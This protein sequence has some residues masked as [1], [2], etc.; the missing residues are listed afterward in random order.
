MSLGPSTRLGPYE[1]VGPIG[2]GGMGEVYRARDGR[3][4]RDV[5]IKILPTSL[6]RDSDRLAR[7]EREAQILAALNHPN[8]AAIHHVEETSDGPALVMELVEGETLAER[9]SRGPIPL[10]EAL[11]IAKQIAE[12]LE[13]AH[14]QGIIH[15]DLKPA[16]IKLRDD[17]TVKVLDFGL[18]KL[19]EPFGVNAPNALS[20]SPTITSPA[21]TGVGVLLGTAAYMSPEQ[22]KGLAA[23][24]RSDVFAFG[25]VLFEVLTGRQAFQ[26]ETVAE[27]LGAVLV[28][29]PD[30]NALPPNLNPRLPELV[31][32]C[33]EKSPKRRWQAVGDLRI[34]VE[35]VAAAPRVVAVAPAPVAQPQSWWRRAIP[36]AVTTVVAGGLTGAAVWS[37]A[38][39]N[40]KPSTS[41]PITR[42]AFPLDTGQQFTNPGRQLV[43][44]SPDGTQIVYV[45]DLHLN[46]RSMADLQARPIP[47]AEDKRGGVLNPV[48]SP[49]GGSIAFFSTADQ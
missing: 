22:A 16:N 44:I 3:L 6:T 1:I 46:L 27:V 17:G 9:I 36:V 45:A 12:A 11:P 21:I 39:G 42:F 29:Q 20:M 4:N 7:F 34:E 43:A 41:P 33:L 2:A 19:S 24:Q 14:E 23:D 18:A 28:A 26:G 48:F 35:V 15:R 47:G 8:I 49:D 25:C 31:R 32:R 13:M 38:A 40:F 10:D 5:A 30:L 37:I